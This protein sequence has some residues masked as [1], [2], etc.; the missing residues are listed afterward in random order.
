MATPTM[1]PTSISGAETIT[2]V[3]IASR[4]TSST[5]GPVTAVPFVT[6]LLEH[7]PSGRA[8]GQ[9]F[10]KTGNPPRIK[11]GAWFSGSDRHPHDFFVG[12]DDLVAHRHQR[13]DG[14]FRLGHRRHHVDDVGVAGGHR[15]GLRVGGL[16]RLHHAAERVLEQ[17]SEAGI[18]ALSGLGRPARRT[19]HAGERRIGIGGGTGG[20]HWSPP[21]LRPLAR[22]AARREDYARRMSSVRWIMRRVA[23]MTLRLAS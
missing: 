9:A 14:D 21:L 5:S 18:A 15:L 19:G 22:R 11:S 1:S 12:L 8:R 23:P 4:A 17:R 13:L 6:L 7:D 10:A 3:T 16:A 20:R 2:S